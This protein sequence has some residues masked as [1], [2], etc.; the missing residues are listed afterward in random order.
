MNIGSKSLSFYAF[1]TAFFIIMI[2]PYL[3]SHGMFMDGIIYATVS[4]NLA[5]GFGS[6]SDLAFS[7]TVELHFR[8]H[9]PLAFW[10]QSIFYKIFGNSFTIEKIYSAT[11]YIITALIMRK[12]WISITGNRALAWLPLLFWI[13]IPII[14]QAARNNLL[15]NTMMV[16][17]TASLYY[18]I[19]S[20][21]KVL[22]NLVLAGFM[23]YCG[24][25]TKGFVALFLWSFPFW[26]LVFKKEKSLNQTIRKMITLIL[27]S[28]F[29]FI[30][31]SLIYP[32]SY[33]YLNDY[34]HVQVENS[35]RNVQTV[36][37]RFWIVSKLL[38]ELITPGILMVLIYLICKFFKIQNTKV[39]H[40]ELV[41]ILLALA[42]SGV[43]PIVISLKQ[44]GFY[45]IPALS[46]FSLAFALLIK[47]EVEIIYGKIKIRSIG[48]KLFT[49]ISIT[50]IFIGIFIAINNYDKNGRD[51][52]KI[53]DISII[54]SVV[55]KKSILDVSPS[56][57][58]DWA[59]LAYFYR[60][61]KISLQSE[62]IPKNDFYLSL[63]TNELNLDAY[64]KIDSS[65]QYI[66]LYEQF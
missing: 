30:L 52:E 55:G 38:K 64:R 51:H 9:P 35:L 20:N 57:R 58:K 10:I 36:D 27:F 25:M 4:N 34:F 16:F 44:S 41:L 19:Q 46:I 42:L 28:L 45:F 14:T 21:K 59:T 2:A 66:I 47:D 32:E 53:N 61:H 31:L 17:T 33:Y 43:L 18:L 50:G 7:E 1:I 8:E 3:L 37:S 56:V 65:F 5:N 26:E 6:M 11:T 29:P 40:K 13:S 62:E 54:S 23:I 22:M 12:I 60:Y 39:E 63:K 15:E 49:L 24:F 48:F